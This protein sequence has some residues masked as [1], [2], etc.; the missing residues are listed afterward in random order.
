[1]F[2]EFEY[3]SAIRDFLLTYPYGAPYDELL[4]DYSQI[5]EMQGSD[6]WRNGAA[7]IHIGDIAISRTANVIGGE[8]HNRRIN[9]SL[10]MWRETNDNIFRRDVSHFINKLMN[11]INDENMKRHTSEVNLKLP[12]FSM[13][14]IETISADGGVRT[15]KIDDTRSEF[16]IQIHV[17]YQIEYEPNNEFY[18]KFKG[19]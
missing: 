16:T 5:T 3:L 7:I 13:T 18:N 15:A 19:V 14:D 1:M 2:T 11:W 8:T 4:I 9:F 6:R 17:D 12:K 10:V